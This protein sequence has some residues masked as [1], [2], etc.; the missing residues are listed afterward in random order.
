VLVNGA[1]GLLSTADGQP[2]ALMSFTVTADQVVAI[3]IIADP[4]RLRSLVS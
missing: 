1:A 3:D 2:T 4:E